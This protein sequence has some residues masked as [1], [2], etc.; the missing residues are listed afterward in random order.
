LQTTQTAS[1]QFVAGSITV[2]V[3]SDGTVWGD[4]SGAENYL[5]TG[6]TQWNVKAVK[7]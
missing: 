6:A 4:W 3:R 7:K 2:E 1:R 5:L